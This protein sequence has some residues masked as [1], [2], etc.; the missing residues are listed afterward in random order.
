MNVGQ[1]K[2]TENGALAYAK[3]MPEELHS[4]E[5]A[6]QACISAEYYSETARHAPVSIT[7]SFVDFDSCSRLKIIDSRSV[8]LVNNTLGR[9]CCSWVIPQDA[10]K[11]E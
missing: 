5:P 7:T 10:D 8:R 2:V 9:V 6:A 11:Y 4:N 3:S 1:I